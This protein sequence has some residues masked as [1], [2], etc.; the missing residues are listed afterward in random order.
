MNGKERRNISKQYEATNKRF[1]KKYYPS[2]LRAIKELS[3]S[4]ISDIKDKGIRE[5]TANLSI[6]LV[7]DKL[8]EPVTKL[9][10]EVGL[11]HAR[12]NYRAIR[13]DVNR[14]GLGDSE[15]WVQEM[16]NLL[17]R[18]LLEFAV[19]KPTETFRNHLLKVLTDALLQEMSVDEVVKLL[20]SDSFARYQAERIVRTEVGRAAN[21]GV[22][23][24]ADAFPYEM[25]KEWI[26]FRD[27]R[28]RG[29]HPNDKKDHY[30]LDGVVVD[31]NEPFVDPISG[32]KIMY[33]QA[34]KGS[35]AM[36]INCRCTYATVPKRDAND[37]LIKK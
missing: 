11:Y 10:K 28:T 12:N 24:A 16:T 1:R 18:T 14:K 5:A 25:T 34:P 37:N 19:V 9:Y 3:S 4:L 2:I 8:I 33:P 29:I 20:E 15:Q 32:E 13:R 26:A 31:M 23:V 17:K 6:T 30:H 36:V 21:T 22:Q 27:V 7:N 35:A